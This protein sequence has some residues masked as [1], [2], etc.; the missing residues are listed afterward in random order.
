MLT[1]FP[2][3][4]RLDFSRKGAVSSRPLVSRGNVRFFSSASR[5]RLRE[6]L[7]TR[8]VP[9]CDL[10]GVTLTIPRQA[11]LSLALRR[12]EVAVHRLR[13][14][15]VRKLPKCGYVW[16]VELQR[17]RM[18]HL[19]LVA[20]L[21]RYPFDAAS[22]FLRLW[23]DIC[24]SLFDIQSFS[25]FL[26]HGVNISRLDG[27]ISAFR[28]VSDHAGKRKQAQL[29]YKGRQWGVVGRSNF[30][31]HENIAFEVPPCLNSEFRRF[32]C[33][34]SSFSV[35]CP[36]VFGSKHIHRKKVNAVNYVKAETVRLWFKRKV[37]YLAFCSSLDLFGENL[38]F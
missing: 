17:N 36:C 23:H 3:G 28:Y 22:L 7:L 10:Y 5:L 32:L 25:A 16:R 31:S 38:P 12:F 27:C 2:K 1:V 13:V 37:Q 4:V 15:F 33:R 30:V 26:L 9:C 14:Y 18:P 11:D 20:Y 29:G 35:R 34:I 24:L 21:P 6:W 19:H 8:H